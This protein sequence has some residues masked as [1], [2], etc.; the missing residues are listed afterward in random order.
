MHIFVAKHPTSCCSDLRVAAVCRNLDYLALCSPELPVRK[1]ELMPLAYTPPHLDAFLAVFF[2]AFFLVF[3]F[4]GS[5]PS[6]GTIWLES[7]LT[8]A[9]LGIL[10]I[11][12]LGILTIADL[13]IGVDCIEVT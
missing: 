4:A 9:D 7:I 12:D 1:A 6:I 8:I 10:T 5:E 3:F 13:G 2:L 11:A